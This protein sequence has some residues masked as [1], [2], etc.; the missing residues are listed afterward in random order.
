MKLFAILGG[1]ALVIV[2]ALN[3]QTFSD[4]ITVNFPNSVLVNGATIPAGPA[5]IDVLRG[6]GSVIL[7][8]RS[9]SGR[10]A[11]ILADRFDDPADENAPKVI[12]DHKGDT[13]R[14]SRILMPDHVAFQVLEAE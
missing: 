9:E 6:S 14:I 3:A 5:T 8:V 11:T 2:G 7:A 1:A 4:R 12:L 13:Y 10:N